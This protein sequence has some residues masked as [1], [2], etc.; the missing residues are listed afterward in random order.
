MFYIGNMNFKMSVLHFK[1]GY[2]VSYPLSVWNYIRF[3]MG[4]SIVIMDIK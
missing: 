1:H 2:R 4:D 3:F